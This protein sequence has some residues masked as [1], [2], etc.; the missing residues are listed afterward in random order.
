[1]ACG[2]PDNSVRG[3]ESVSICGL[4]CKEWHH[5]H[6]HYNPEYKNPYNKSVMFDFNL[7]ED[8]EVSN[9]QSTYLLRNI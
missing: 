1:M 9:L 4:G 2:Y 6:L 8:L 3:Y 5:S 7:P